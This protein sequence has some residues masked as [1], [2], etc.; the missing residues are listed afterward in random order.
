MEKLENPKIQVL[1][2]EA[3]ELGDQLHETLDDLENDPVIGAYLT[4]RHYLSSP[5]LVGK[6]A[7]NGSIAIL[8]EWDEFVGRLQELG[9]DQRFE[10]NK[11]SEYEYSEE[12]GNQR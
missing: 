11:D 1:L 9:L 7:Y 8:S 4:E 2:Q 3:I 5:I 10:N 6:E 12:L